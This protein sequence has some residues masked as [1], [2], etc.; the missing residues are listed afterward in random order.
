MLVLSR[1][2]NHRI[3][4]PSLGITLQILQIKGSVVKVGISA[5]ADVPIAREETLGDPK[6]AELIAAADNSIDRHALRNQL[7]AIHLK[8]HLVRKQLE[9]GLTE[10]AERTI[11]EIVQSVAA[12]DHAASKGIGKESPAAAPVPR[13]R[14][15]VVEDDDNERELLAGVLKMSGFDVETVSDGSEALAYLSVNQLPD[16]LLLDM[17]LPRV[18]G[19]HTLRAIRGDRRTEKVNVFAVSGSDP[20]LVELPCGLRGLDGWFSKPLDPGRLIQGINALPTVTSTL[21]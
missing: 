6:I 19:F 14:L 4:F 21:A 20:E 7:N 3:L 12:M 16:A 9:R 2:Q 1:R 5:P 17:N 8:I 10:A 18:N 11:D 13:R 15:L